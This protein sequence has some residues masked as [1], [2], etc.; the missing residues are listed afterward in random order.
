M[1]DSAHF[2]RGPNRALCSGP[3]I[4]TSYRCGF[5]NA[6]R[7]PKQF[8]QPAMSCGLMATRSRVRSVGIKLLAHPT[9]NSTPKAANFIGGHCQN[10]PIVNKRDPP[11]PGSLGQIEIK[12]NFDVVPDRIAVKLETTG[13]RNAAGPALLL[14]LLNHDVNMGMVNMDIKDAVAEII[15]KAKM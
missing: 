7:F 14:V 13:V 10:Q 11:C 1:S 4:E 12:R 6:Q 15:E 9:P 8:V 2:R 5:V 3:S